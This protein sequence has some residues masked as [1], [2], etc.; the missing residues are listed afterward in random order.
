MEIQDQLTIVL[1]HNVLESL[2][3]WDSIC[4]IIGCQSYLSVL[5]NLK[6]SLSLIDEE[7]RL[8]NDRGLVSNENGFLIDVDPGC[9]GVILSLSLKVTKLS[10]VSID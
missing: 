8:D 2:S 3:H 6:R 4:V 9:V 1:K 5:K 10:K 7:T